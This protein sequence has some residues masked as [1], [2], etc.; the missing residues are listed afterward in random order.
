M[1]QKT[2]AITFDLDLADYVSGGQVD[3]FNLAFPVFQDVCA[4]IPGLKTTW[5]IRIDKQL[6]SLHG[7]ADYIFQAHPEKIAWLRNN[8]HQIEWHF[9]SYS[10]VNGKWKQNTNEIEVSEELKACFPLAQKH[11]LNMLRMGWAYHTNHTMHTIDQLGIAVDCS[12]MPR[13]LY[14]WEMSVRDWQRCTTTPYHP[15]V[16]DYQIPGAPS[17]RVLEYPMTT[18]PIASPYDTESGVIRYLNPCYH[19]EIFNKALADITANHIN[20][21]AHPYEFLPNPRQHG[22]LA[23][24]KET[25]CLNLQHLS[26]QNFQFV[27][28]S[29]QLQQTAYSL[30]P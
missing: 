12:A 8:G 6:S 27:T 22:M 1:I 13:P 11:G 16:D 24:S 14:A 28:L 7:S 23:F 25:M 2:A 26:D 18:L 30:N 19:S 20:L 21:I 17:L 3:E 15:S 9:H 29:G 5:F 4:R 10:L